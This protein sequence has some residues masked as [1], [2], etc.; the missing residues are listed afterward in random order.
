MGTKI[1]NDIAQ[2]R[3]E[4]IKTKKKN[5]TQEQQTKKPSRIKVSALSMSKINKRLIIIQLSRLSVELVGEA[6]YSRALLFRINT[7]L[8]PT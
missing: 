2:T 5:K 8:R 6:I 3:I 7:V 1:G 4:L